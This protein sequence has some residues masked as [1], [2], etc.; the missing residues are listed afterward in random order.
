MINI[1]IAKEDVGILSELN[2]VRT[3]ESN[4]KE[5]LMP[6]DQAAV[7]YREILKSW[8]NRGWRID[9]AEM[10]AKRG[11]VAFAIP[12]PDRRVSGNWVLDTVPL[13]SAGQEKRA[14]AE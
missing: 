8:E 5:T 1:Q 11:D 13:H 9:I 6:T 7:R 10:N 4:T 12:C 3:P 2:P 14:A